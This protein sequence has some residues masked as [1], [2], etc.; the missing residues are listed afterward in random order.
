MVTVGFEIVVLIIFLILILGLQIETR[1]YGK[2]ALQDYDDAI[3]DMQNSLNIVAQVLNKLPEMVPQ[4]QINENPLS[5]I[6]DFFKQRAEQQASL[7][8]DQLRDAQGQYSDATQ[9]EEKKS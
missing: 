3:V 9:E 5:Q 4:F 6:L 1:L 2:N 8:P 7:A